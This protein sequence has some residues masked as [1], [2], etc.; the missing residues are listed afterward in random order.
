LRAGRVVKVWNLKSE[1]PGILAHSFVLPELFSGPLI[2][3]TSKNSPLK[4]TGHLFHSKLRPFLLD[5][6]LPAT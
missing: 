5:E 3:T 2:G 6:R 1:K 4:H